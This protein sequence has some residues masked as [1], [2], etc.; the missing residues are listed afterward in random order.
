M[1]NS[2]RLTL[3]SWNE[4]DLTFLMQLRNNVSLQAKLLATAR[5]STLDDVMNWLNRRTENESQVFFLIELSKE[6]QP[7]GYFQADEIANSKKTFQ[8]GICIDDAFQGKGFGQEV[9][10]TSERYL[11]EERNA[12]RLIL[13][14]DVKNRI[15]I[16]C[17]HRLNFKKCGILENHTL[18]GDNWCNALMMEKPLQL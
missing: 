16:N 8:I 17:Y 3:R 12:E 18:V 6:K 2:S 10:E 1:I 15:A 14:V 11:N 4:S 9:L 7:I 13:Y 5:G